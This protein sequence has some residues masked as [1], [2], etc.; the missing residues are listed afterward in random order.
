MRKSF[1]FIVISL[2]AM[3]IAP[4]LLA[5]QPSPALADEAVKHEVVRGDDLH[6]LAA[7][8]YRNPRKWNTI[9]RSNRGVIE[10]PDLIRPGMT[11][12]IPGEGLRIF[13]LP[14]PKWREKT[15]G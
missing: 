9:F 10:D 4:A 2:A 15:R 12:T 1:Y 8:Y 6:L 11:L 7:Y 5:L 13:P 3:F 14:Y